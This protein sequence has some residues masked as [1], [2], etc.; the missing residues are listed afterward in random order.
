[1]VAPTAARQ[2]D[3]EEEEKVIGTPD[4]LVE[5]DDVFGYSSVQKL[6]SPPVIGDAE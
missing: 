2:R 6:V 4:Y 3:D 1:M 5:A